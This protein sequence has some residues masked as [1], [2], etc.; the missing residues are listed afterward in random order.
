[1]KFKG[2]N[3]KRDAN[4]PD[5]VAALE[6]IGCKVIRLNQPVDLLVGFKNRNFLI[7][8]KDG[9]KVKSSQKKTKLQDKFFDEWPGQCAL[10]TNTEEAIRIICGNEQTKI[11]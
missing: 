8:V 9:E 6:K 2:Y 1:V 10:V 3:A 5:I 7:E 11:I 4:E